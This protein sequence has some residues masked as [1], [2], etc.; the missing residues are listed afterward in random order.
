MKIIERIRENKAAK[1]VIIISAV[2]IIAGIALTLFGTVGK[3]GAAFSPSFD[4]F[5]LTDT[6]IGK[7]V[8]GEVICE[9][10]P[11]W[12]TEKGQF[13]ILFVY[14]NEEDDDLILMGFDVP[15][16]SRQEF[17]YINESAE[18][19][20]RELTFG[21]TVCAAD[22][23]LRE[24]I[25]TEVSDYYN[26]LYDIME[27]KGE[28]VDFREETMRL[29]AEKLSSYYIDV[30][31]GADTGA[32]IGVGTVLITVGAVMLL[33][34]LLGKIFLFIF[35]GIAAVLIAAFF[36]VF[37][38]K[39]ASIASIKQVSDGLYSMRVMYGY[40]CDDFLDADRNTI[41]GMI[42]WIEDNMFFGARID[43][44]PGNFGCAAFTAATPDGRRLFGRN[45]D[46]PD[47]DTL[48]VFTDPKD[49]YASYS[50]VDLRFFDIGTNRRLSADSLEAKVMMLAA[51]YIAMDGINEAGVGV[52]QL[53][54]DTP[55]VHQDSGGEYGP[56]HGPER[57]SRRP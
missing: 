12:E 15:K 51:P 29:I 38:G 3:G 27:E 35:V 30:D 6:D 21:G 55:E 7:N 41:D 44:D 31:P 57:G 18:S 8:G 36:I 47:T 17:D 37:G 48:V 9:V 14:R 52:A 45:F 43:Y 1:I 42:E 23:E 20:I 4:A 50:N 56:Q 28:S 11:A 5:A 46:Y 26:R 10:M 19:S 40:N 13:Y 33:T 32:F 54:L 24:R 34:A 16:T 25:R 39:A 49:G 53:Q 2:L 22:D